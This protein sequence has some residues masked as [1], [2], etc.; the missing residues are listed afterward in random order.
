M[1]QN[2]KSWLLIL[3][4]LAAGPVLVL[5][6][7][8]DA[9]DFKLLQAEGRETLAAVESVEWRKKSG[10]ERGFK[11]HVVFKAE[12]G[13]EV[14]GEVSLPKA[15]G[16]ALKD[17]QGAPIVKLRYLP[18]DPKVMRMADATDDSQLMLWVGVVLFVVGAFLLWRKL[19]ARKAPVV[20]SAA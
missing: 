1:W 3:L 16:Q 11:G 14:R 20:A 15:L 5:G 7:V 6:S 13:T 4:L 10:S 18:S 17:G 2:L 12:D 9:R 8:K 19:R